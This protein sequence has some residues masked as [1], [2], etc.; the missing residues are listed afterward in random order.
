MHTAMLYNAIANN[1][2]MMKPFMVNALLK[3]GEVIKKFEPTVLNPQICSPEVLAQL[4]SCMEG[5]VLRGTARGLMTDAYTFAGK[6][7]T[8]L[9]ADKGISYADKMYQ[10]SFAGYF[11]ANDPQYTI[12]V[13]IRNRPH[14]P[15]FYGG[16]V[17]GPVFREVAD[18]LF[19]NHLS[20]PLQQQQ[21]PT[22]SSAYI[23]QGQRQTIRTI[24]KAWGW[25]ITDSAENAIMV[26]CAIDPDNRKTMKGTELARSTMP[27]LAGV[28]LK[29]AIAFCEDRGLQVTISGK[30]RVANQSIAA[31]EAIRRGQNIHL[32]LN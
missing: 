28:G 26:A 25:K 13:V 4:K 20:R 23:V 21:L 27:S 1:G 31:G 7:G 10:S 16:V 29:D 19:A 24:A 32:L 2:K 11:P 5:V 12:V 30:G 8:S 9:V 6:T 18:R 17:A 14:A 15:R 3:D 22:D